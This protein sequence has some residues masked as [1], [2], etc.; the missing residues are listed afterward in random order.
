M[1][2]ELPLAQCIRE[3]RLSALQGLPVATF[4]MAR[5]LPRPVR[6]NRPSSASRGTIW[7]SA[8]VTRLSM[9]AAS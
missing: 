3:R 8:R 5:A 9:R 1:E 2:W 4:M 6:Q 7:P